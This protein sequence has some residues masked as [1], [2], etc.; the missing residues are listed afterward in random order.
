MGARRPPFYGE[1]EIQIAKQVKLAIEAA[2]DA[3]AHSEKEKAISSLNFALGA[4]EELLKVL[5][6]ND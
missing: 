1:N 2:K 6:E 4:C 5:D 3:V